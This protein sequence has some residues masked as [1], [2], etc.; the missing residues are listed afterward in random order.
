MRRQHRAKGFSNVRPYQCRSWHYVSPG[1]GAR[2]L[3]GAPIRLA[4][5]QAMQT[6]YKRGFKALTG[7][8]HCQAVLRR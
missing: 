8:D 6:G 3:C 4:Y 2:A 1:N 7:C 5:E